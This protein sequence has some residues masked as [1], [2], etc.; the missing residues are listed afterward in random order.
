MTNVEIAVAF[1]LMVAF[2]VTWALRKSKARKH[3]EKSKLALSLSRTLEGGA[4]TSLFFDRFKKYQVR[5]D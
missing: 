5:L 2:I 1:T 3:V 4:G